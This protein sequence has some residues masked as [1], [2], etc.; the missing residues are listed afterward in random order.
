MNG[1]FGCRIIRR[2][3]LAGPSAPGRDRRCAT[4][5]NRCTSSAAGRGRSRELTGIDR[6]LASWRSR[7]PAHYTDAHDVSYWA[8]DCQ[9]KWTGDDLGKTGSYGDKPL[10][11]HASKPA[12]QPERMAATVRDRP[13]PRLRAGRTP[14]PPAAAHRPARHLPAPRLPDR[15]EEFSRRTPVLLRP[16]REDGAGAGQRTDGPD[17]GR[18]KGGTGQR[19]D[20]EVGAPYGM[21]HLHVHRREH[22]RPAGL[23][24]VDRAGSGLG[25]RARQAARLHGRRHRTQGR[26]RLGAVRPFRLGDH[27]AAL[28]LPRDQRADA[29]PVRHADRPRRQHPFPAHHVQHRTGPAWS[30]AAAADRDRDL[31]RVVS[32]CVEGREGNRPSAGRCRGQAGRIDQKPVAG[33]RRVGRDAA[34]RTDR[35]VGGA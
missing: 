18:G 9:R 14:C 6:A 31:R 2:D 13:A 32:V 27:P 3:E 5:R 10:H 26:S 28:R 4:R 19:R 30:P 24:A 35:P 11:R 20:A 17:Q 34:G 29:H 12:R 7:R 25:K 8:D 22:R 15:T 23:S 21:L 33:F 16:V 1:G